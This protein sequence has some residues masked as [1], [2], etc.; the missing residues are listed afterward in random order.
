MP[1]FADL[2][3]NIQTGDDTA[4]K[5]KSE[6]EKFAAEAKLPN[7]NAICLNLQEDGIG[8]IQYLVRHNEVKLLTTV[9]SLLDQSQIQEINPLLIESMLEAVKLSDAVTYDIIAEF[10]GENLL[11]INQFIKE[12]ALRY[13]SYRFIMRLFQQNMD[14]A[15]NEA[16]L[17]IAQNKNDLAFLLQRFP[18]DLLH[19]A[20]DVTNNNILHLALQSQNQNIVRYIV[21][22]AGI[23]LLYQQ[24][25]NGVSPIDMV[26]ADIVATAEKNHAPYNFTMLM[27][28]DQ[29]GADLDTEKYPHVRLAYQSMPEYHHRFMLAK[30]VKPGQDVHAV[31]FNGGGAKG[32][33]FMAAYREALDR[34]I[35]K[36]DTVQRYAGT[37]AGAITAGVFAMGFDI[38]RCQAELNAFDFKQLM[39][40]ATTAEIGSVKESYVKKWAEYYQQGAYYYLISDIVM[41]LASESMWR[42]GPVM[43]ALQ[44]LMTTTTGIFKPIYLRET[45]ERLVKERITGSALAP[46]DPSHITFKDLQDHPEIFKELTVYITNLTTGKTEKCSAET[47]PTMSVIDGIVYSAS[48][49]IFFEAAQKF[50]IIINDHGLRE[51]KPVLMDGK[52]VFCCD[53]GVLKNDPVDA[54]DN[55]HFNE[56]ALTFM[57]V[58]SDSKKQYEHESKEEHQAADSSLQVLSQLY[59]LSRSVERK[60][61]HEDIRNHS[62]IIYI[63]T[64]K[65]GTLDF[66]HARENAP[67]LEAA[68][69]DAVID[70]LHRRTANGYADLRPETIALL[71]SYHVAKFSTSGA[72]QVVEINPGKKLTPLQILRVYAAATDA[73]VYMLRS[74]INP[75]QR[76]GHGVTAMA[77]AARFNFVETT[78]RLRSA[79]ARPADENIQLGVMPAYLQRG[80]AFLMTVVSDEDLQ[81]FETLRTE[82]ER[83][84]AEKQQLDIALLA[85]QQENALLRTKYNQIR[86]AP[87]MLR[88]TAALSA[89]KDSL[90]QEY[91]QELDQIRE[92]GLL[93]IPIN[94]EESIK[95]KSAKIAGI[96]EVLENLGRDNAHSAAEIIQTVKQKYPGFFDGVIR[97][98]AKTLCNELIAAEEYISKAYGME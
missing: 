13:S 38:N 49:P 43:K 35:I 26:Y 94:K 14:D 3:K 16:L 34:N 87:N 98:R 69:Q 45:L 67:I 88:A 24:N 37:S 40:F 53:G 65:V 78:N 5:V 27:L 9:L 74:I 75:N 42:A 47:S 63:D 29:V 89:Y 64:K 51:R 2:I 68:G 79:G 70:Y 32:Q 58:S 12:N 76:D 8:L 93:T 83:L 15:S 4:A 77:I 59:K 23:Q 80:E 7:M 41:T 92:N 82:K 57:L 95:F 61:I 86:N 44:Q 19:S 56:H 17:Q 6:I 10:L 60:H 54:F 1:K 85:Q 55:G 31:A 81:R 91:H 18:T 33:A 28:L 50:E 84:E 30:Q 21:N 62:R 20:R 90:V 22:H 52:P 66:D 72:G 97:H 96:Q 46:I 39:N 36:A 25:V 73:E 48:F 71:M 11:P